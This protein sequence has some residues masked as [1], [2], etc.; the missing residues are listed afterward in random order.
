MSGGVEATYSQGGTLHVMRPFIG[1]TTFPDLS[2]RRQA[3]CGG[4]LL[5]PYLS[6]ED[7]GVEKFERDL[8][9]TCEKRVREWADDSIPR[10]IRAAW[11][12]QK[13][14]RRGTES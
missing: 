6:T 5:G 9:S 12:E 1:V 14:S 10:E 11:Q 2:E 7:L 4:W 13:R 3:L 8:C